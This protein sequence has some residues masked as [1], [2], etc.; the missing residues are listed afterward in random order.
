VLLALFDNRNGS[1]TVAVGT[2]AS[3]VTS[4]CCRLLLLPLTARG[5]T[6][7]ITLLPG[8]SISSLYLSTI[9]SLQE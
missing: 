5:A 3:I 4:C 2:S 6:D 1:S 8:I 7:L 9:L